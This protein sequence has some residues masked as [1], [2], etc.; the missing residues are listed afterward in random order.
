MAEL[1]QSDI[2]IIGAGP[3]GLTAALALGKKGIPCLL[4]DKHHFPREKICGDGLSGKV[5]ST[6]NKINPDYVRD[7]DRMNF[8]TGSHAVR[9]FSPAVK[10]MELSFQPGIPSLP[11]GFICKRF[12]FD[13]FLLKKAL[14]IPEISFHSG[15][16]VDKITRKNGTVSIED[17][18]GK[19]V[20]KTRLVLFAAGADRSLTAQLTPSYPEGFEEGIGVR[21]YFNNVIGSDEQYA[22]EIHFLKE[23][24]PW[25]LWIFPFEDGSANVGLALPESLAKKNPL[26]LKELL[27][28]L[29]KKYPH[30]EKRFA[31][32]SL[33]GKIEAKRLPYYNGH[34]TIAGDNYMLLGDA[35]RLIDPFTG[36]GI[37][38]AMASG[39]IAAEIAARCLKTQNFNNTCTGDY[40]SEVYK[41][42]GPDLDTGIKLQKLAHHKELLNMII[43]K[44][45]RNEKIRNII[46]EMIYDIKAKSKLKQAFSHVKL[47]SGI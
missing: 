22:I 20:I 32:S 38:N 24:L 26:S 42:L 33:N 9:F 31:A 47:L 10:M 43:G 23:L 15:I 8:V 21:G 14:E 13:N 44:A 40:E 11:P 45:A 39:N 6:L 27:F 34:F 28:H 4:I 16:Q 1:M 46:S 29:I 30:L 37:G 3:A 19:K 7:L 41:K 36:E 2:T 18:A 5:V 35:A 17:K 12:A 25:Y